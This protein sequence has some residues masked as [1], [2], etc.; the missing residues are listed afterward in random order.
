MA[1][2][3]TIKTQIQKLVPGQLVELFNLVS[4]DGNTSYNFCNGTTNSGTMVAFGG[5][6]YSPV[7]VDADGW[8]MSGDGKLP[9]PKIKVSN[10]LGVLQAEVASS[11]DLVGWILTRRRTF[12]EYLDDSSSPDPSAQFPIDTYIV[13]R[14]TKQNREII[15]WELASALDIEEIKIPGKMAMGTC[16]HRY[17]NYIDGAFVDISNDET[18]TCP[19][20]A[21]TY[22]NDSGGVEALPGDDNCGRRLRDCK[23][24]YG[25]VAILPF[26]GFPNIKRF[27]RGR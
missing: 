5:V 27:M 18:V 12:Y 23:L 13:D 11:N 10:V 6:E 14:K 24:R 22:Y 3:T 8:E 17:R 20:V 9:R 1:T 25:T 26:E 4:P 7:P 19:Y 21:A 2:N 16:T 15:E